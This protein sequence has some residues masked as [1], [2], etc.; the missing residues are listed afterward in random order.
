MTRDII[1]LAI[2]SY[3]IRSFIYRIEKY[4]WDKWECRK[5]AAMRCCLSLNTF[6]IHFMSYVYICIK[7]Y[8]SINQSFFIDSQT[9]VKLRC[10]A[11]ASNNLK[12]LLPY[13]T[14]PFSSVFTVNDLPCKYNPKIY[15]ESNKI[16]H[17]NPFEQH[18]KPI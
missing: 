8:E 7:L 4:V 9:Y 15:F 18:F 6:Y 11:R 16:K 1:K 10:I 13:V 5:S 12:F 2:H 14:L 3:I 17:N